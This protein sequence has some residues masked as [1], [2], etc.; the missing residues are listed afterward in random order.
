M[1]NILTLITFTPLL[2]MLAILLIPA[3][4]K[5]ALRTVAAAATFV[6]F[7]LACKLWADFDTTTPAYQFV[8]H[9]PWIKSLGVEYF[10]GIDGLSV[11]MVWLTTLLL[12]LA[13]FASWGIDKGVKGYML[14]LLLLEIGI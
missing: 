6:P 5:D 7:V 9:A 4:R 11:P 13:V 12:F 14:L 1:P 3:E 10:L 2:G 8:E